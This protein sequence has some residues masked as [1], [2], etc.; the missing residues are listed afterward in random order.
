ME[1]PVGALTSAAFGDF[2]QVL[3]APA[4]DE[5]LDIGTGVFWDGVL[6]TGGDGGAAGLIRYRPRDLRIHRMERHSQSG[7]TFVSLSPS[8]ALLVVAPD[9]DGT[10]DLEGLALFSVV[11]G[12]GFRLEPGTWHAS[13]FPLG[14][15][16][17]RFLVLMREGTITEGTDWH[18]ME[19]PITLE[20]VWGP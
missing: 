1:L 2:G 5:G 15:R 10:P 7:Q 16:A 20:P 9:A 17:H 18:E 13:P 8:G 12:A 19:P 4:G 11:A 14:S 3:E 6:P